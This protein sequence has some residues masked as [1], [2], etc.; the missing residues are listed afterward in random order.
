MTTNKKIMVVIATYNGERFIIEQMDS[1][2][3]QTRHVDKVLI[4]DD[5]SKDMTAKLVSLY[6]QEHNLQ[7]WEL[8]INKHNCGYKDNFFSLIKTALD[9]GAEFIFLAD[10]DDVWG[11]DRVE[12]MMTVVE[13]YSDVSLLISNVSP[14][15]TSPFANKISFARLTNKR[16]KKLPFDAYWL[17]A[18]R[19]GCSY[20]VRRDLAELVVKIVNAGCFVNKNFAH[21]CIIW[22]IGL[23]ENKVYL[24]NEDSLYFRRHG[25]NSSNCHKTTTASR[26]QSIANEINICNDLINLPKEIYHIRDEHL[27]F[28]EKQRRL[29]TQRMK[30]L[31]R[32]SFSNMLRFAFLFG[33]IKYYPRSINYWGDI[34][35]CVRNNK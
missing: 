11:Y 10:Q 9:K 4:G 28:I 8:I 15:Y 32:P 24:L 2:R 20:L 1:I 14:F 33:K 7:G 27:N 18:Q 17:F 5:L 34:F 31:M 25:D 13:Q 3:K 30:M 23:L 19:P 12:K 29:F 26:I 16:I 22:A 6:I 21:D 35:Y